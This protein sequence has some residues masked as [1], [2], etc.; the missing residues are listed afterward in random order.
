ML[1]R[2]AGADDLSAILALVPRLATAFVPP[3]WRDPDEMTATDL[4]V[5][6]EALSTVGEDPVLYVAEMEGVVAG[7]VH[8]RSAEDYYRRGRRHGHVADLV[9]AEGYEGQGI[10]TALLARA[11]EWCRAQSY[12]WMTLGVFE[13]NVRAEQLYQKLGFRRD[14]IRL[15]KPLT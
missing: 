2:R 3:P 12:D 7:F 9:V 13:E 10:A 8:V 6:T 5:V 1:I 11:E 15:L 14:V 4:A